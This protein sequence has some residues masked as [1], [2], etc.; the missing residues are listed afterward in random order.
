MTFCS[1]AL[2]VASARAEPSA[3]ETTPSSRKTTDSVRLPGHTRGDTGRVADPHTLHGDSKIEGANITK[4]AGERVVRPLP[5]ASVQDHPEV[6]EPPPF[7][8]VPVPAAN[9]SPPGSA[10]W[11]APTLPWTGTFEHAAGTRTPVDAGTAPDVKGEPAPAPDEAKPSTPEDPPDMLDLIRAEIKSRLPYFQ[12]CADAARRRAGLEIHRLQATWFINADGT[13]KELRLDAVPDAPLAA[14][15]RRA[16][17]RP[18]PIQ[19]GMELTIPTP[20]VFVR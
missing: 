10:L 11:Q 1:W 3:K 13:I 19:P 9:P 8:Y 6:T 4:P 16:G 17:S 18:F 15:L 14:C 5:S 2:A 7:Q 12:A 20:I